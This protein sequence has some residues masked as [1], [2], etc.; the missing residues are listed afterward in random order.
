M[1]QHAAAEFWWARSRE[2]GRGLVVTA[3][4][5]AAAEDRPEEEGRS[6]TTASGERDPT[7]GNVLCRL[8]VYGTRFSVGPTAAGIGE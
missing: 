2:K 7:T 6:S 5:G 4:P 8:A 3:G 1:E